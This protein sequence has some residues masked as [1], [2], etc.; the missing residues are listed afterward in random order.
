MA[1][2][3]ANADGTIDEPDVD[4]VKSG[5]GEAALIKSASEDVGDHGGAMVIYRCVPIKRVSAYRV[6][7]EPIEV[8]DVAQNAH[9][10]M[11]QATEER[12]VETG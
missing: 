1:A 10:V 2:P 11:E 12:G 7:V 9:R 8:D 3:V 6:K 5:L 4:G